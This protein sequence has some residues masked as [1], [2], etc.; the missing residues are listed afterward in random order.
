MKKIYPAFHSSLCFFAPLLCIFIALSLCLSIA[1]SAFS[2]EDRFLQTIYVQS[3]DTLW[4]ISER[5]LKNPQSWPEILKYNTLPSRDPTMA[6]PGMQLKVPILLIKDKFRAA[7]LMRSQN[8][9]SF[10]KKG[11]ALWKSTR[12]NME[13]FKDDGLRTGAASSARVRFAQGSDLALG[14]NSF[15]IIK[16]GRLGKKLDG[17]ISLLGGQARATGVKVITQNA[18]VY[19]RSINTNYRARIRDDLTTVVEVYKGKADVE[20][21]GKKVMVN[22]GFATEVPINDIPS[23]P[24]KLPPVPLGDLMELDTG[25]QD[26]DPAKFK[27]S[28]IFKASQI[29]FSTVEAKRRGVV[30]YRV[31]VSKTKDFS[32]VLFEKEYPIG[33]AF[34]FRNMGIKDGKYYYRFSYTDLL[35]FEG[36]VSSVRGINVDTHPPA[37]TVIDPNADSVSMKA[38]MGAERTFLVKGKTEPGTFTVINLTQ[39]ALDGQGNFQDEIELNFGPNTVIVESQDKAGNV[40]SKKIEIS[41]VAAGSG[42]GEMIRQK[43]APMIP[44]K[45]K[46]EKEGEMLTFPIG[47]ATLAVILLAIALTL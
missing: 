38:P 26:Q 24:T 42:K 39:V 30:S 25:A 35:G 9:V 14:S 43:D 13:L 23:E 40:A 6:L 22:E 19:P 36:A 27:A 20:A 15:A 2:R 16:P 47:L 1:P 4:S 33:R 8:N 32:Q 31:Q 3:G 44:K 29:Q 37:L 46:T 12:R 7:K 18:K 10:R 34:D 21:K 5:Y 28:A 41:L 11:T 45:K 17:G